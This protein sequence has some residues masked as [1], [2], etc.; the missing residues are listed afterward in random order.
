[1]KEKLTKNLGLKV[2]SVFIAFFVWLAVVNISNPEIPDDKEV[3]LEILNEEVLEASGLTYELV[4]GRDTVTVSYRVRTLD[5]AS[6]HASDFRAY[7]DLADLYEPTG[8]VPVRV[9]VRNN[10]GLLMSDPAANPSVVRVMTEELQR[11]PFEVQVH[12]V[13]DTQDGYAV[14][15]ASADPSYVTVSGPVS[16]V[17][18]ISSV[19]IEVN[20]EGADSNLSGTAEP[21]FYDANGNK[22]EDMP[23]NVTVS[24]TEIQYELTILTVKT[25][26]ID[27]QTEGQVVEGYRFTGVDCSVNSVE[28]KGLKSDLANARTIVIP[29]SQLNM[30]GATGDRTFTIDITQYLPSGLQLNSGDGLIEVTIRVEPLEDRTYTLS[31]GDITLQGESSDYVY[32]YGADSVEVVVRGLEED[33][34]QLDP[35]E[36][37]AQ[38]DVSGM[39][40]GT[41]Q[42]EITIELSE[43]YEL[44]SCDLLPITVEE[45][46]TSTS[47]AAET[48]D[49]RENT[50]DSREGSAE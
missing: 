49:A 8:S 2:I 50:A 29:A 6:I 31:T 17:G 20:V 39:G 18:Q 47:A 24:Q 42:G 9:E 4:G 44:V 34:D 5:A 15:L 30:D 11:K 46:Q 14:G 22:L 21:V 23:D 26:P 45:R 35:E 28:V 40:P 33:L 37:G 3:P 25:L 19:G 12:T 13:G 36:M 16:K 1:M 48:E 38:L 7:I 41:H 10:S 43:A 32:E 27:P